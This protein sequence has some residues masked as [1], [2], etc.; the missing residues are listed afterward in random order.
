MPWVN[1]LVESVVDQ[2]GL[3]HGVALPVWDALRRHEAGD[4]AELAAKAAV[5]AVRFELPPPAADDEVRR[6]SRAAVA[7][8]IARIDRA[9][10]EREHLVRTVGDAPRRPWIYLIVATGDIHEDIPRPNPQRGPAPT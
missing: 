3:E 8:G 7:A 6:Q 10:V 1:H 2:I 9:R 4:L 5:G